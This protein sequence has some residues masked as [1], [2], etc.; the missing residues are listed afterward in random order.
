MRNE[1]L[2]KKLNKEVK[3]HAKMLEAV[4]ALVA[5]NEVLK[6]KYEELKIQFYL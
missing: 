6:A 2:L 1:K 4:T 3:D 5:E